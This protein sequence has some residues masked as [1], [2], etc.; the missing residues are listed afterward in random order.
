MNYT[1]YVGLDV[2][3]DTIAVAVIRPG[4]ET[5]ESLGIILNRPEALAKLVR[6]LGTPE[7]LFFCYE[8]GP[9]GYSIYRQLKAMGAECIVAAPSLVPQRAGD[10]VKTDRRDAKKLARFLRSGELTPVWVPDE[11]QEAL[12]D[13]T[14]AREDAKEDVLRKRHQISKFLLRLEL[15]PPAGV[16]AWTVKHRQW[17]EGLRFEQP[18]QAMVLREYLHA[19][20]EAEAM[21]KRLEAEI[22]ELAQTCEQAQIIA[23]LQAMRGVCLITAA[24]VVAEVGDLTRFSSPRQ[25]MSYAGLVPSEYSSGGS[26]HRGSITK[27]GNAHLRRVV[28]EAAWNYRYLPAVG[29]R[30]KKR[31]EG[32]P[33]RIKA[34]SW[35]AQHRLN[36]KFRRL[37]GRSKPNQVAAV[38]VA[39][40]LLGFMWAIAQETKKQNE[41]QVA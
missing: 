15:R 4:Q 39:R 6:K 12:R 26:H 7:N 1:T 16:N 21:A 40:E 25:L 13:L 31:Q 38:A 30:L 14:R 28:V 9:C 36:L 5:A 3:K 27:S 41:H 22:A 35:Q 34:I 29:A 24:T 8:A 17:L 18:A 2:H 23:A 10:R 32:L 33:E 11:N 19:L 37:S 20:D